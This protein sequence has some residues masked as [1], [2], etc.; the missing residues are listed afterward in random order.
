MGNLATTGPSSP[1]ADPPDPDPLVQLASDQARARA[2]QDPCVDRC[3][4][5]TVTR[6]G[7]PRV[8]TLVLHG[9]EN[10]RLELYFNATSPK[11]RQ[12][13]ANGKYELLVY[14]PTIG[15]QYRLSGGLDEIPW[16][17]MAERWRRR[18]SAGKQL[19]LYY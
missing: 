4:L 5:A 12:L 1:H 14:W 17:T 19:D 3:S 7:E 18:E 6:D 10:G 8:R 11:W 15:R 2:G 9:V 16:E 13:K